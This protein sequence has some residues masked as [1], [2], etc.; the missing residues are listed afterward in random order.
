MRSIIADIIIDAEAEQQ[1][2]N[3]SIIQRRRASARHLS[4]ILVVNDDCEVY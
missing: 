1:K 4:P 3:A 2:K